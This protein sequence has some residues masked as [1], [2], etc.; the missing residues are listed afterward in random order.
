MGIE[1]GETWK[2]EAS[3]KGASGSTEST[4]G[5]SGSGREGED[6]ETQEGRDERGQEGGKG[7]GVGADR[8]SGRGHPINAVGGMGIPGHCQGAR[9]AGGGE[10]AR[11]HHLV[12]GSPCRPPGE[13]VRIVAAWK[14]SS[15]PRSSHHLKADARQRREA[16]SLADQQTGRLAQ[17][18]VMRSA[19]QR[20]SGPNWTWAQRDMPLLHA[21]IRPIHTLLA[22]IC[23]TPTREN[24]MRSEYLGKT[25][26]A[27]SLATAMA[28]VAGCQSSKVEMAPKAEKAQ[29]MK[30]AKAETAPKAEKAQAKMEMA[31]VEHRKYTVGSK[32]IWREKGTD[33]VTYT[34]VSVD[35]GKTTLQGTN[36]CKSTFI[37]GTF[38]QFT[39]WENC[40]GGTGSQ[41][42]NRNNNIFPLEVGKKDSV[43]VAGT[44][45][46]GNTWSTRMT[47]EVMGTDNVTVPAGTFDTYHV[48][49]KDKW[50]RRDYHYAPELGTSVISA[51][52]PI[53]SSKSKPYRTELVKYE[54]AG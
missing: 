30:V 50:S 43:N 37:S 4:Q 31:P 40:R 35:D 1:D 23:D 39:S 9:K 29:A 45:S 38:N 14:G 17:G 20:R 3:E 54:R 42:F 13:A 2:G 19:P 8:D 49:C 11:G 6:R 24:L 48:V 22:N 46:K 10:T 32:W 15:G 44:N 7:E 47:C 27:L 5:E 28:V 21:L 51:R 26:L 53:G 41:S 18:S 52:S 16:S 25:I 36:G 12:G 33:D 34:V